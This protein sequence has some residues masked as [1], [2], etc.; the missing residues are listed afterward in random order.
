[1]HRCQHSFKKNS[2]KYMSCSHRIQQFPRNFLCWQAPGCIH[3][4]SFKSM[5][6]QYCT[7]LP[8]SDI[9]KIMTYS[10]HNLLYITISKYLYYFLNSLSFLLLSAQNY[11]TSGLYYN[12]FMIV[13]YDHKL[14]S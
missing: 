4:Y 2:F 8:T 10:T 12:C 1:M 13:I 6:S 9:I 5:V 7:R 3:I 14:R 11:S